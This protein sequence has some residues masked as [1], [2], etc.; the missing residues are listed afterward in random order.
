MIDPAATTLPNVGML[1]VFDPETGARRLVNTSSARVRARF[2]EAWSAQHE[3][4]SS[5]L[6]ELRL[7]VVNVDTT[8]DYVPQLIGF[9]RRRDRAAR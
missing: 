3:R 9:F 2:A 1:A 7:Y 5:L 4:M 8:Q 6:R